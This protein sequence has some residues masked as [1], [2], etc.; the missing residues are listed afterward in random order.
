M[1]DGLSRSLQ[2]LMLSGNAE[3]ATDW[4]ARISESPQLLSVQVIR[5]DMS[6]AFRDGDTLAKVNGFLDTDAFKRETLAP[7]KINDIKISEFAKPLIGETASRLDEKHGELTFLL[8][9]KSGEACMSC[10]GYD[11]SP[12][13]G[14]LRVTTSVA[15]AQE[16]IDQ[17]LQDTILHGLLFTLVIGLLLTLFIRKQILAPL[18]QIADTTSEIAEGNL[19]ARVESSCKTELGMLGRSLNHMV[20]ALNQTTVSREYFERIM[21]SMGEML[22]VTDMEQRIEFANPAVSA[23]LGYSKNELIGKPIN[24]LVEGGQELTNDEEQALTQAGEVKSLEKRFFHKDGREIPVLVTVSVMQQDSEG[25]FQVIHAGRDI[26]RQKRTERELRLAAQVMES[27]SN[28]ILV[29]DANANIV[30]VNPAF[31]EIT[32]YSKEEVIGNNPRILSSGKQ[33]ANFYRNM[34]DTLLSEGVW[35]GEIWNKRKSGDIYPEWLSITAVRNDAGELTNFVSIFYDISEQ[36]N[37]EQKLAHLAHHDQLTG[38]PNRTLF[39]DRL[40]HALAH[41]A[42]EDH[43]IGLMFIDIDGF[44]A[45]NDNHGHDIGD[46]LLCVIATR[47]ED[48]VRD[49][50]TV[51]RLGGDEFVIILENLTR[52]EDIVQVAEKILSRFSKPTMASDIACN[53]G[54]SIGIAIS[55]EDGTDAD[56]LVRKADTA[57]YLAK[58]SGKQQ[59]RIYSRDCVTPQ[60]RAVPSAGETSN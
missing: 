54:C 51:A 47:L 23:T 40:E 5:K 60:I 42:R 38:L 19:D 26:S 22:F 43:M 37:L 58:S 32:G 53:I 4:I 20:D 49:A 34:W 57:M 52:L 45:V 31:C 12:V 25:H 21:S 41:A 2:T 33:S 46:A 28:A 39:T 3:F 13:R 8:P 14:V 59:Y 1:A 48:M 9:V 35:S 55:P 10:H 17:A 56:E 18:E 24:M 6:E 7:R 27:D 50:D 11:S 29:C 15:H 44:K 30:L 16:R 36:K